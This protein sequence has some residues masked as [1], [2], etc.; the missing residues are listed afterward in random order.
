[1]NSQSGADEG[2]GPGYI[3]RILPTAGRT[4]GD[5]LDFIQELLNKDEILN[6][7]PEELKLYV[8][9]FVKNLAISNFTDQDIKYIVNAFDDM[10]TAY[11]MRLPPGAFTWDIEYMFTVLRPLIYT[12]ASRAKNGR[13]RE[14]MATSI[15]QT[16]F[17]QD[18]RGNIPQG[19]NNSSGLTNRIKKFFGRY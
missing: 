2:G 5:Q 15:N 9:A 1:M 19:N 13:E 16:Y 6:E 8:K 10:K 7:M 12:E 4:Y 11:L 3:P 17:Q 18:L 14:L